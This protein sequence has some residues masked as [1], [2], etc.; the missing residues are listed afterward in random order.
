MNDRVVLSELDA[1]VIPLFSSTLFCYGGRK[2]PH[3]ML[4][5]KPQPLGAISLIY[6]GRS[7]PELKNK[8]DN[9]I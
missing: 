8:L 5:F 3:L 2:D 6:K 9:I 4:L 1:T 7:T